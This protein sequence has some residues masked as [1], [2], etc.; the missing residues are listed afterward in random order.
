MDEGEWI[1]V[2]QKNLKNQKIK[3]KYNN[4]YKNQK[5]NSRKSAPLPN[6]PESLLPL[7]IKPSQLIPK[8]CEPLDNSIDNKLTSPKKIP[9]SPTNNEILPNIN[10]W[11]E[12]KDTLANIIN[13]KH[14]APIQSSFKFENNEIPKE[15]DQLLPLLSINIKNVSNVP[16]HIKSMVTFNDK[17]LSKEE[18]EKEKESGF[19]CLNEV[20]IGKRGFYNLGNTC[21]MSAIYQVYLYLL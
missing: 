19:P 2:K 7:H 20:V 8:P 3:N 16:S 15:S 18:Q 5:F 11:V 9:K 21:Y 12:Q 14:S 10:C 6:L 4:K 1:D 17:H 13:R